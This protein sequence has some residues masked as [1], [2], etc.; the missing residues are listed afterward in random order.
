MSSKIISH[1]HQ[2]ELGPNGLQVLLVDL[3]PLLEQLVLRK[4][5]V[6]NFELTA[7]GPFGDDLRLHEHASLL[8]GVVEAAVVQIAL[9]VVELR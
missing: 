4:L 6:G 9:P 7:L 8:V 5:V 1:L 3:L 2:C